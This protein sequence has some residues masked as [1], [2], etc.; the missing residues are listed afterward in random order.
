MCPFFTASTLQDLLLI[1]LLSSIAGAVLLLVLL[2]VLTF[3]YMKRKRRISR[4]IASEDEPNTQNT[5]NFEGSQG[6]VELSIPKSVSGK[7]TVNRST[8]RLRSNAFAKLNNSLYL[9][10]FLGKAFLKKDNQMGPEEAGNHNESPPNCMPEGP[11]HNDNRNDSDPTD[12]YL[13]FSKPSPLNSNEASTSDGAP[14]SR[15]I[16]MTSSLYLIPVISARKDDAR[17]NDEEEYH[18][19]YN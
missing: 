1:K 11:D 13:S 3:C 8:P 9:R 4:D 15:N 18:V 12:G 16:P 14:L 5:C 6:A 17:E 19:Y 2:T 7:T 10:K